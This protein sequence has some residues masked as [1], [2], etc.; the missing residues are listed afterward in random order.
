MGT[1]KF[2]SSVSELLNNR[3]LYQRA[4]EMKKLIDRENGLEEAI[5]EIE[6]KS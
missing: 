6:R 4:E 3:T 1:E 5:K 2:I